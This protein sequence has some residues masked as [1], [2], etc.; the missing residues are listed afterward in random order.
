MGRSFFIIN[1][2]Y[3]G[4]KWQGADSVVDSLNDNPELVE[5]LIQKLRELK[6]L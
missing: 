3:E 6:V 1:N 2:N 4:V 5:E